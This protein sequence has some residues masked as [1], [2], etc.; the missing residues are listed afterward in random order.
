MNRN[1]SYAITSTIL[2]QIESI[3]RE[4]GKLEFSLMQTSQVRLRKENKLKTIHYSLGIEGNTL[5]L[6]EVRSIVEGKV[7]IGPSKDIREV[8]NAIEVYRELKVWD[9]LSE[10][11]LLK[12]HK[13]LMEGLVP[14]NGQWRRGGGGVYKGEIVTDIAPPASQVASLMVSLFEFI[15]TADLPYLIK[16]CVFHYEFEFIHP[17]SDGNGRMGRLWQQLFL[18]KHHPLFE[19]ISVEEIIARYQ[20]EYYETFEICDKEG[21]STKFIEWSLDK[22]LITLQEMPR[23]QTLKV[24][25]SERIEMAADKFKQRKFSR[26]EYAEIFS[27]STATASRDLLYGV[28]NGKLVKEG[29]KALS[30]YHYR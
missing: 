21:S 17:F 28:E 10:S 13:I 1:P 4:I 25:P 12:A 15:N 8:K 9:A 23:G 7:V 22:I 24:S 5:S 18:M 30:R 27:I 19:Y 2:K 20:L 11:S 3:G 16:A 26:K 29:D 6:D 14:D